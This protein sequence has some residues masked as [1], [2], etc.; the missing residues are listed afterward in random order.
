[1]TVGDGLAIKSRFTVF[2]KEL[3]NELNNHIVNLNDI[4][5]NDQEKQIG[6][7]WMR[8][9][10]ADSEEGSTFECQWM[11]PSRN[12]YIDPRTGRKTRHHIGE[13]TLRRVI[14]LG[15]E[16]GGVSGKITPKVLRE[17]FGKHLLRAGVGPRNI[18]EIMG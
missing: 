16:K 2:P 7:V 13:N 9:K 8:G 6:G 15:C 1:M 3:L 18:S 12:L 17:N 5:V 4:F 14:R 10:G 11:F